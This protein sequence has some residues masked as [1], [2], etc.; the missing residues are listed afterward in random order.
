[1]RSAVCAHPLDT[2]HPTEGITPMTEP[3][4]AE[5]PTSSRFGV[6]LVA[7]LIGTALVVLIGSGGLVLSLVLDVRLTHQLHAQAQTLTTIHKELTLTK[8]KLAQ[9][10]REY[11]SATVASIS[12]RQAATDWQLA[13][14][15]YFQQSDIV[16]EGGT[17][18]LTQ[19]QWL[20]GQAQDAGCGA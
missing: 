12:C 11:S 10:Q 6:G 2:T 9:S 13:L 5:K 15:E 7:A 16:R 3:S 17:A 4:T 1:M 19:A 14:N 20:V 8:T 18:D